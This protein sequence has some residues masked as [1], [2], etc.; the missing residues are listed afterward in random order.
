MFSGEKNR[1]RKEIGVPKNLLFI[2]GR[3]TYI[4]QKGGKVID[5]VNTLTNPE[6][7]IQT[8]LIRLK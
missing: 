4:I 5:I 6:K 2:P 3:V 8:A 7:H 1:V